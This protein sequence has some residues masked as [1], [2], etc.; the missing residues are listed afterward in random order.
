MFAAI[1]SDPFNF[2]ISNNSFW[3]IFLLLSAAENE[4]LYSATIEVSF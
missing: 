2:Y 1:L 4:E 3:Y